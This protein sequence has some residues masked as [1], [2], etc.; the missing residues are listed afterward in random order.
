MINRVK[1]FPQT[2]FK[3]FYIPNITL[4]SASSDVRLIVLRR[5]KLVNLI[6]E[7]FCIRSKSIRGFSKKTKQ[8]TTIE[9]SN[10]T[11]GYISKIQDTNLKTY[12]HPNV[13]SSIIYNNSQI[14]KQS[15]CPSIDG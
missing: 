9:F 12:M 2:Y 10:S 3:S 11:P 7:N 6:F 8:R 4:F 5:G 14:Q 13:H 15:S 1:V